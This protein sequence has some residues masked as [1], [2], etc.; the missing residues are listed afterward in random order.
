MGGKNADIL[1]GMDYSLYLGS[2]AGKRT[3]PVFSQG[4]PVTDTQ[5]YTI[6]LPAS[7]LSRCV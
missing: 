4:Q 5:T 7:R 6:A 3:G 1:Y 2:P